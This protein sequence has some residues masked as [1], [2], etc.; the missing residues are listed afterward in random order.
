MWQ[1][2]LKDF[3]RSARF[4]VKYFFREFPLKKKIKKYIALKLSEYNKKK[5]NLI[6]AR[7]FM[8]KYNCGEVCKNVLD[9]GID[10]FVF[11]DACISNYSN[12][13]FVHKFADNKNYSMK[14]S[15]GIISRLDP[16]EMI[17][18]APLDLKKNVTEVDEVCL[19]CFINGFNYW[20]FTCDVMPRIMLM[21]KSGYKGKYLLNNHPKV[22]EFTEMLGLSEDRLIYS[23][24][25]SVI[26]AKKVY[27]FDESYGIDIHGKW[28]SDTRDFIIEKIEEKHGTLIDD[29]SPKKLY[30]SRIGTRR[31]LNEDEIISYLKPLGFE[32]IIPEKFSIHEQIK[33]FAN[34]DIIVNPHGANCTNILY[35]KKGTTFVECFGHQWINPCMI[36]AI[37]LLDL[38]YRMICERFA[39]YLPNANKFSNYVIN[40]TIFKCVI[41]KI[42]QNRLS[43]KISR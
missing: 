40:L 20:H 31:I 22:K 37:E 1:K 25:G 28:L 43:E 42:L 3:Y 18:G 33:L 13:A 19:L 15:A 32:V 26:Q 27:L 35:S 16:S 7:E 10:L 39:D 9:C 6:L 29:K 38:D 30:V 41:K 24:C 34:A 23:V 4:E 12:C 17:F 11:D 8:Q 5:F 2:K 21:E 14:E 36:G